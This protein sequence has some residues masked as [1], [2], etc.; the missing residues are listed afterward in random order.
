MPT[1]LFI[2]RD[3]TLINMGVMC[4]PRGNFKGTFGDFLSV[5][6]IRQSEDLLKKEI[7]FDHTRQKYLSEPPEDLL[8]GGWHMRCCWRRI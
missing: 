2:P 3:M 4:L 7:S 5:I 6:R 8:P 1:Y